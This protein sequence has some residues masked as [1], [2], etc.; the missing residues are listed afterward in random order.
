MEIFSFLKKCGIIACAMHYAHDFYAV[1][2]Q[3]VKDKILIKIFYR[4][5][6]NIF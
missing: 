6:A 5:H 3:S 1:I 2:A 4:N